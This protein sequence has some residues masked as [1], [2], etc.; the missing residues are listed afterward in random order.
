MPDHRPKNLVEKIK[1]KCR[2]LYFPIN[3]PV[4]SEQTLCERYNQDETHTR[5][6]PEEG[7]SYSN[8]SCETDTKDDLKGT[9]KA[10]NSPLHIVW[11][12]RW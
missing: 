2:V 8:T 12:H 4:P 11:P 10:S 5:I 6:L 7:R 9:E 1:P 3:F